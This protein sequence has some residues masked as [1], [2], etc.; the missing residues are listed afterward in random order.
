M[1]MSFL[2]FLWCHLIYVQCEIQY[3]RRLLIC[4]WVLHPLK[5]NKTATLMSTKLGQTFV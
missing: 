2:D 5:E 3:S 1:Q 4:R